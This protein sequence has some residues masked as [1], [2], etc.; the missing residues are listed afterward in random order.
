MMMLK[1]LVAEKDFVGAMRLIDDSLAKDPD[2]DE[3]LYYFGVLMLESEHPG[4]ARV[5]MERLARDNPKSI[6][7]WLGLGRAWDEL[8]APAKAKQAILRGFKLDTENPKAMT[9]LSSV[10]AKMHKWDDAVRW[11]DKSL[12]IEDSLQAK[13]NKSFGL[14][15]SGRFG[16]GWDLYSEGV[17]HMKWRDQRQY[18]NLDQ[19]EGDADA[20]V[21]WYGEQGIGDQ[22][23]F[24]SALPGAPVKTAAINCAPKLRN[25]FADSFPDVAVH[26][27]QFVEDP[28]WWDTHDATH[29]APMSF[30]HREYRRT[31]EAYTGEPFLRANHE[32]VVMWRALLSELPDRQNIGIA[33]TGGSRG[34]FSWRAKSLTL[35]DFLPLFR[36]VNANWI[37]L[38]YKDRMDEIRAFRDS[39]GID[40]HVWPWGPQSVDYGDTA[41]LV[42][43]LDAIVCVPTAI[44]HLA[45]GL[46]VPAYVLV[47]KHAHFHE[48]GTDERCRYYN[49][50]K[51]L[52]RDAIGVKAAME[53][54]ALDIGAA[55]EM[56][57]RDPGRSRARG[58]AVPGDAKRADRNN[59]RD[60]SI[61]EHPVSNR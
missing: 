4:P 23:A 32:K 40:I 41:A 3:A 16:E 9:A 42:A 29:M 49:S 34:S 47:Q 57:D 56:P 44:Y 45:G 18:G 17:G 12:A 61:H 39:H 20:R 14:L 19:W 28:D 21:I 11:A 43:N 54:I 22:I 6:A 50:V 25:L 35:P 24:M 2:N 13:I 30:L 37:D 31:A 27:D 1:D 58:T 38:E 59:G 46:G 7:A 52:R 48:F 15:C 60:G 5:V 53:Q 26:G 10:S 55:D 8:E 51:F 33:W 36:G